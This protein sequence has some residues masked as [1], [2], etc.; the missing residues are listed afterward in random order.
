MQAACRI[1]FSTHFALQNV[2]KIEIWVIVIFM[3]WGSM[4]LLPAQTTSYSDWEADSS[5][6]ATPPQVKPVDAW[7]WQVSHPYRD[8]VSYLYAILPELPGGTYALPKWVRVRA[9]MTEKL[10]LAIDPESPPRD[11]IHRVEVPLDST[12]DRLLP[13]RDYQAISRWVNDSLS[14]LSQYKLEARY[15]SSVLARQFLNDYCLNPRQAPASE[16]VEYQLKQAL[17]LPLDVVGTGWTRIAWLDSYDLMDQAW[18]LTRVFEKR[19]VQCEVYQAMI[20]AYL[21]AD[22]DRVWLLSQSAPDMGY[23]VGRLLSARNEA[24]MRYLQLNLPYQSLFAAVNA[25]QLPGEYG[26]LQQLREAGYRIE[27]VR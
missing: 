5:Q 17:S 19:Q 2:M 13:V 15:P 7:L 20:R 16:L 14:E 10:V 9:A 4:S 24:W 27:A 8:K 25:A 21:Q 18:H 3:I 23:N 11:L 12:L 6:R 1:D 22:I 26:L